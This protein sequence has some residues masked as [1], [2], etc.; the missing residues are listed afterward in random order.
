MN[1]I[2]EPTKERLLYLLKVLDHAGTK[3]IT[4]GEIEQKLGWSSN[5]IRKD[6]SYLDGDFGSITGYDAERLKEAIRTALGLHQKRTFCIVGL[7]RLGSAYLNF[8]DYTEEGF[9]LAAGFDSSVNRV[10]ILKSPIPLFPVYKM[11]EVIERFNIEMALLCVPSEAAQQTAEKLAAAGIKAI[12]NF[13][14]V[15][16]DLPPDIFV[17]NVYVVN[18]LRSLAVKMLSDRAKK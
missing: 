14:P 16:L 15:V 7:G 18:D 17:K 10:E 6:I 9:E 13:A 8:G 3:P 2:S 4:S 5:T 11:P 12:V 1:Q